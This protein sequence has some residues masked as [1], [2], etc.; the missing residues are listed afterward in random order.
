MR[1]VMWHIS[2][3]GRL[4]E[5][6]STAMGALD[7]LIAPLVYE[8]R[9]GKWQVAPDLKNSCSLDDWCPKLFPPFFNTPCQSYCLSPGYVSL[10]CLCPYS[11]ALQFTINLRFLTQCTHS[12]IHS[13]VVQLVLSA[14]HTRDLR[15]KKIKEKISLLRGTDTQ[16]TKLPWSLTSYKPHAWNPQWEC[17]DTS[18]ES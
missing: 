2:E 1:Q 8:D 10:S 12:F 13:V 11:T 14:Y 15:M 9:L 17:A 4:F 5:Y 7:I 6:L 3:T 18:G 16:G